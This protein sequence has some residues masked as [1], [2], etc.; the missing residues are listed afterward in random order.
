M[1]DIDY[2]EQAANGGG[3]NVGLKC[4][5]SGKPITVSNKYGMFCE[6]KCDLQENKD[7]MVKLQTM[8]PGVF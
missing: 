5:T 6:D 3:I 1:C 7:A 2:S 8:F 4:K